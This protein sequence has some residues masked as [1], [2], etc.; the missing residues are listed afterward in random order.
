MYI[1]DLSSYSGANYT[2]KKN[3]K[4]NSFTYTHVDVI[5]PTHINQAK[6]LKMIYLPGDLCTPGKRLSGTCQLAMGLIPLWE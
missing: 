6:A 1:P 3:A 5:V 2:Q 4:R